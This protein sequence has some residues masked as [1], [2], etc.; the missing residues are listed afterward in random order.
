MENRIRNY[1]L[2]KE[3]KLKKMHQNLKDYKDYIQQNK[4]YI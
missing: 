3:D 1:V 4:I 2:C